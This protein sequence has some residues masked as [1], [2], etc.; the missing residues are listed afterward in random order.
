MN[1]ENSVKCKR[2][3]GVCVCLSGQYLCVCVS[4]DGGGVSLKSEVSKCLFD[5]YKLSRATLFSP[6]FFF[7]M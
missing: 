7:T 1:G 6:F 2:N 3:L 4:I 5:R